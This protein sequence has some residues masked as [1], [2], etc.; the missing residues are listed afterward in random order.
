MGRLTS[1]LNSFKITALVTLQALPIA[2]LLFLLFP[3]IAGGIWG[4]SSV[5]GTAVSGLSDV[6]EPGSISRIAMSGRVAFRVRLLDSAG[7]ARPFYWRVLT[8]SEFNG[9]RW[10]RGTGA[11]PFRP[12]MPDLESGCYYKVIMEPSGRT[13]LPAMDWPAGVQG[14]LEAYSDCTVRAEAP[15]KKL[16]QYTISAGHAGPDLMPCRGVPV[17]EAFRSAVSAK[18]DPN[19]R[20]RALGESWKKQDSDPASILRRA[21]SYFEQGGFRYTLTPPYYRNLDQFIFGRRRGFCGHYASA[22]AY[23]LRSAG[24]P[25]RIVVGYLGAEYN[26]FGDYYI[27]RDSMAHAWVEVFMPDSGWTRID[28]TSVVAPGRITGDVTEMLRDEMDGP[29]IPL[30]VPSFMVTAWHN[31]TLAWDAIN[32]F[33]NQWIVQYN[34]GRQQSLLGNLGISRS[35]WHGVSVGLLIALA[36]AGALLFLYV[37]TTL[38]KN[39][40]ARDPVLTAYN[41]FRAKLE[42]AGIRNDPASGPRS[43]ADKV[44]ELRPDLREQV[45]A[46]TGRYIRLRYEEKA[47]PGEEKKFKKAVKSF[48]PLR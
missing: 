32:N 2:A 23:L 6:L 41:R 14:P 15:V 36:L 26:P 39:T 21:L 17:A 34:T 45:M 10:T 12:G 29:V 11:R 13:W 43:Y 38:P 16:F 5:A 33:W 8:L 37:L 47:A 25:A 28:A 44:V 22:L 46:I 20:T 31:S 18:N 42:R 48:N 3:R 35:V 19:P 30:P 1:L 7:C 27:V 24:L 40:R 4:V 9:I